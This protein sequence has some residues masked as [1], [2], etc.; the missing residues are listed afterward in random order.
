MNIVPRITV[1]VSK[2]IFCYSAN[3]HVHRS[4]SLSNVEYSVIIYDVIKRFDCIDN[5]GEFK[6]QTILSNVDYNFSVL[7]IVFVLCHSPDNGTLEDSILHAGH[8]GNNSE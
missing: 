5:I 4:K 7:E 3:I 1:C 2:W 8:R 6:I